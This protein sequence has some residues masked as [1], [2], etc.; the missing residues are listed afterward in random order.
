VPKWELWPVSIRGGQP[1]KQDIDP[2]MWREGIDTEGTTV[3]QGDVGFSRSRDGR[4]VDFKGAERAAPS[5]P[6]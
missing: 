5:A 3:Q 4:N 1:R 6:F 2:G